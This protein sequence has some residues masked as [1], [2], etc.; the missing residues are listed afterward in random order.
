MGHV[1]ATRDD[2]LI[3]T[4]Q[5]RTAQPFIL[6][7][8]DFRHTLKDTRASR[9]RS[10]MHIPPSPPPHITSHNNPHVIVVGLPSVKGCSEW[11]RWLGLLEAIALHPQ[12]DSRRAEMGT[13]DSYR[14][15]HILLNIYSFNR[16]VHVHI[17]GK[18]NILCF[19]RMWNTYDDIY[20]FIPMAV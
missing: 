9:D 1:I 8:G 10:T 17:I 13:I 2:R 18:L 15:A 20:A 14:R 12:E 19:W 5:G 7:Y 16:N 11:R 4:D 6:R 3:L